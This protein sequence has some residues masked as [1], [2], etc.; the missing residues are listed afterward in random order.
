MRV[1]RRTSHT[2]T[3][4]IFWGNAQG[5]DF[6]AGCGSGCAQLKVNVSQS[7]VQTKYGDGSIKITFGAGIVPPAD[8]MFVSPT[9]GDFRLKP[10]S[11]AAGKGNQGT[12]LGAL[13]SVGAET[14][15]RDA[16]TPRADEPPAEVENEPTT[17][18]APEE[19]AKKPVPVKKAAA[20]PGHDKLPAKEAF[21]EAKE[22]GTVEAWE[23]FVEA[24]PDGFHANL[25]R[26]YLK[27][28][29]AK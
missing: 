6:S 9:K 1:W 19:P 20:Q 26:A 18:A 12:D 8:P 16:A 14:A 15:P 24:Y 22:L 3:N 2:V 11:P 7:M 4:A 28:L 17:E 27:K 25:A 29:D 10:G 21:E 13:Q 5:Q 23:A